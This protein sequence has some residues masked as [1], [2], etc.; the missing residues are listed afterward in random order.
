MS[1]IKTVSLDSIISAML[2]DLQSYATEIRGEAMFAKDPV[3]AI[4]S[5]CIATNAP[6][7]IMLVER[8]ESVDKDNCAPVDTTYVRL[9]MAANIGPVAGEPAAGIYTDTLGDESLAMQ[10]TRLRARILAWSLDPEIIHRGKMFYDEFVP[11]ID[12]NGYPLA[13]YSLLFH[14]RARVQLQTTPVT[15]TIEERS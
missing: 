10:V 9:F 13:A 4:E 14:F 5:L 11:V 8:G 15:I 3:M 1:L 6:R 12:I 7:I 2:A